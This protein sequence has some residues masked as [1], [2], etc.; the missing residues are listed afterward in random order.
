MGMTKFELLEALKEFPDHARVFV[1]FCI[2]PNTGGFEAVESVCPN[3]LGIQL[4]TESMEEECE[5][6]MERRHTTANKDVN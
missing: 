2:E 6:D 3:G 1:A 5:R 4:N